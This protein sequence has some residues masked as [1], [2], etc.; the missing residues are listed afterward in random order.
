[1]KATETIGAHTHSLKNF[2]EP[3]LSSRLHAVFFFSSFFY[4]YRG[5]MG[6]LWF[7]WCLTKW[8]DLLLPATLLGNWSSLHRFLAFSGFSLL[9]IIF[10]LLLP[11]PIYQSHPTGRVPNLPLSSYLRISKKSP[12]RFLK[13]IFSLVFSSFFFLEN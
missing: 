6:D 13:K 2:C 5:L 1:M 10:G 4:K 11:F 7:S 9:L 3:S 12:S 8:Q